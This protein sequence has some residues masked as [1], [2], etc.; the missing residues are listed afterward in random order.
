MKF[1]NFK[2]LLFQIFS[3]RELIKYFHTIEVF[4]AQKTTK[5]FILSHNFKL[6]IYENFKK[7][8]SKKVL[9]YF[10]EFK[11]KKQR[12]NKKYKFL[13]LFHNKNFVSS[14][15]LYRGNRWKISE[16][17]QY[18]NLNN[19]L[20]IFDFITNKKFRNLGY[21]TKLLKLIRNKFKKEQ[22]IIYAL[23]SNKVSKKAIINAEFIYKNKLKKL[24]G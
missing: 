5:K 19:R 4:E 21:Y 20:I 11:E 17:N 15:W 18:I 9:E 14:G 1:K 24:I 3:P 8:K 23:S 12:F 22:L 2:R 6:K 7:I 10:D 16:I 13:V